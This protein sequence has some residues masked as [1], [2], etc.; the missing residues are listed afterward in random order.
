MTA[1]KNTIGP[2]T[3]DVRNLI[4]GIGGATTLAQSTT[5]TVAQGNL[6]QGTYNGTDKSMHEGGVGIE[7]RSG[8]PPA[9]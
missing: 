1:A 4:S 3:A 5:G 8:S 9:A 2:P 7:G 6:V